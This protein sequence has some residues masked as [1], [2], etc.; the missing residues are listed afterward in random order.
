MTAIEAEI[1]RLQMKTGKT[2]GDVCVL[3]SLQRI[4]KDMNR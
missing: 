4:M 3:E 2:S 1:I